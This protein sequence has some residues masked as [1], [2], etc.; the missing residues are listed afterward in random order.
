M[1]CTPSNPN[2]MSR[3]DFLTIGGIAM[4]GIATELIVPPRSIFLPPRQGWGI[5]APEHARDVVTC[6]DQNTGMLLR[7]VQR[8]FPTFAGVIQ[9]VEYEDGTQSIEREDYSAEEWE[10]I[11]HLWR[12]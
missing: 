11:G 7:I 5:V 4:G 3:R 2:R 12:A 10:H 6:I 9:T 1:P 8:R